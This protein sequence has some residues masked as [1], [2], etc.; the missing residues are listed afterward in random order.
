M[1]SLPLHTPIYRDYV[2][3]FSRHLQRLGYNRPSWKSQPA[4]L[5]EFLHRLEQ[6]GL[7]ELENITPSHIQEHY[8]YLL[9]RP[10]QQRGGLLSG[11]TI[12]GHLYA[13]KL[14]FFQQETLGAITANPISGL[15]FPRHTH[16]ERAVLTIEQVKQLYAACGSLRD[17]ALLGIFYGCGLR[18]AEA[19]RLNIADVQFRNR[20]LYVRQGKGRKRRVV[21]MG[22]QV[23]GDLQEYFH[24]E[25]SQYLQ[26][27]NEDSRQAFILNRHGQRMRGNDYGRKFKQLVQKAGLP[28]HYSLHHLRHSIA[29][30]LLEGG[31]SLE[32]VRDFLG[33][34]CLESTQIYTRVSQSYL[35]SQTYGKR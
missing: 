21:P 23:A 26:Q 33:H 2:R 25:R 8:N 3:E 5:R 27:Q 13:L 18:R 19:E 7:T 16:P 35:K 4:C 31:L 12:E 34:N 1:K 10:N 22:E 15:V 32:Q 9:E 17:K 29:T 28:D 11:S 30:H 6:Q 14:F 20:L 24:Q